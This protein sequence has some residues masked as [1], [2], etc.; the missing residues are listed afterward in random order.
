MERKGVDTSVNGIF[1]LISGKWRERCDG[2]KDAYD[3]NG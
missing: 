2:G 1:E 3:S